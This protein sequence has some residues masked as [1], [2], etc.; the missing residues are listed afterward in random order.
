MTREPF[1]DRRWMYGHVEIPFVEFKPHA[2]WYIMYG[3]FE[4]HIA[5]IVCEIYHFTF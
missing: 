3:D 5:F 4:N 2:L 1:S